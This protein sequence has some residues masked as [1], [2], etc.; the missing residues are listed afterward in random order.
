LLA[1]QRDDGVAEWHAVAVKL[2]RRRAVASRLECCEAPTVAASGAAT[3]V[4]CSLAARRAGSEDQMK[5]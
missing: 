4:L 1:L 3:D 2:S 5:D